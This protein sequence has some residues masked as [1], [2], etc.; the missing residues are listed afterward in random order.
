MLI[1]IVWFDLVLHTMNIWL[2]FQIILY[3]KQTL[4][5]L[6]RMNVLRAATVSWEA[7]IVCGLAG[8]IL[9][10]SLNVVF[11]W[12]R[13]SEYIVNMLTQCKVNFKAACQWDTPTLAWFCLKLWRTDLVNK[14]ATQWLPNILPVKIGIVSCSNLINYCLVLVS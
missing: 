11:D 2:G 8:M 4:L 1:K 7:N 10:L 12:Q 3:L 9:Y 6:L 13:A 14:L 5:I